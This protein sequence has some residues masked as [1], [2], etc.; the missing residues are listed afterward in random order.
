MEKDVTNIHGEI[1]ENEILRLMGKKYCKRKRI[2]YHNVTK[3][4]FLQKSY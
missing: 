3:I 4:R 2:I 1:V